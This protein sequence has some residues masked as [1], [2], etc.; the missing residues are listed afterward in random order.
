MASHRGRGL[1]AALVL[2]AFSLHALIPRGF[3]P[4]GGRLS[5]QICPDGFPAQLLAGG[6][7]YHHHGGSPS[8][9][10]HCDFG[11][12]GPGGP[13]TSVSLLD[14]T[15]LCR[16]APGRDVLSLVPAVRLVH[17][18]QPRGPPAAA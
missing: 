14:T 18:P 15:A 16:D 7:R 4:G 9:T 13:I 8:H 10:D 11:C 3:M 17:L 6:A 12:A 2:A 1:L 5:L